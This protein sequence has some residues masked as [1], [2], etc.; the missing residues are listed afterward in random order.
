M[1]SNDEIKN[2]DSNKAERNP[3]RIGGFI[4]GALL[5][6]L[7]VTF[8]ILKLSPSDFHNT[9][10]IIYLMVVLAFGIAGAAFGDK[11]LEN[12]LGWLRWGV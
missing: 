12:L 3:N 8:H 2:D 6:V 7:V 4:V 9:S 11:F 5:G 1:Q 10:K